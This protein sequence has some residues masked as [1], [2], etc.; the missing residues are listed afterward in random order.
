MIN[1]ELYDPADKELEQL[2]LNARKLARKYNLT[3]EDQQ[4]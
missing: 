3:D 4:E 1:G 2:R